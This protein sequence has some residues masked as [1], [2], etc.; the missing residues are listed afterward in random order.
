VPPPRP[1]DRDLALAE[2]Q[3]ALLA[4]GITTI[5]D[6]GTSIE[7]W[8]AF[9]RAG[10]EGRLQIR[11]ISYASEIENMVAIAGPRPT[12]WLY[13]DHLRMIGVKLYLDGALG[14]RGA[15]L[16]APYADRPGES[17]LA[18]LTDSQLGN[19]F[20]RASMDG[21]QLAVHA[22]GDRANAQVLDAIEEVSPVFTG[23]RRW[24]IEHAQ[25]V[26]PAD[27]P[28]FAQ[29]GI[30]A[31]MQ[32]V[33]ETSDRVMAEVRLGP[34]RLHGAYAWH[35]ILAAGGRIAFGS[36][37]P[38]ES[39]NPFVGIA[40]AMTR[41]DENGEPFGGWLPEERVGRLTAISGFT[42]DAAYAGF[43]EDRLGTLM[44][45]MRADF[46]IIDADLQ[47]SSPRDIRNTEVEEVWIGGKRVY[48]RDS[49]R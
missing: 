39:P 21:F 38:V 8:Q 30:I 34:E 11:I 13:D 41:E 14:S 28:R 48:Q 27:I 4:Q 16:K 20:S 36:D 15:W 7:D 9:R 33:H 17:G 44:P 26:D 22:I 46:L 49:S 5:H 6:M 47:L 37:V 23:D 32:P 42:R 31:S 35:S 29:H 2:A 18:F 19:K 12:P 25:I 45:G 40:V 10:D 43:A 24:R 1:I 3:K